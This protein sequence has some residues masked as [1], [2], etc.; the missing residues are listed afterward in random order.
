MKTPDENTEQKPDPRR[1]N[2]RPPWT[3]E[4]A[5]GKPGPGRPKGSVA[6]SAAYRAGLAEIPM[7]KRR[8]AAD[9][10]AANLLKLASSKGKLA[11]QAARE[12][13]QATEGDTLNAAVNVE[14]VYV[15]DWRD[16]EADS[17]GAA[18]WNASGTLEREEVQLGP[19]GAPLAQNHNGN[20]AHR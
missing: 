8:T 19:S 9:L 11:V 2:L 6:L 4:T 16:A 1:A 18:S 17:A 3:P 7:R 5:P 12:I 14:V 15:N 13:R 20:G 10:I